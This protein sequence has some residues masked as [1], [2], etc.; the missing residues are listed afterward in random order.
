[1]LP[2][3]EFQVTQTSQQTFNDHFGRR[4]LISDPERYQA[5]PSLEYLMFMAEN[6]DF[7]STFNEATQPGSRTLTF[8]DPAFNPIEVT[9]QNTYAGT[10]NFENKTASF[11]LNQ[12][13]Y[14]INK[15]G[16]KRSITSID[17]Y[18]PLHNSAYSDY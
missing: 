14:D 12:G 16:G 18:T 6:P 9:D 10:Y 1:M 7:K 3:T 17:A 13:Y 11:A 4:A 2:E 8:Q 5:K 15:L